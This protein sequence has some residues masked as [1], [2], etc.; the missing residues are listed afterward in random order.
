MQSN[1]ITGWA[2]SCNPCLVC[3]YP[4]P[5]TTRYIA[6]PSAT[7]VPSFVYLGAVHRKSS[8]DEYKCGD[9]D[10]QGNGYQAMLAFI[11]VTSL[12]VS[13]TTDT[14]NVGVAYIDTCGF[15]QR[16]YS[17]AY[18]LIS[19]T[20]SSINVS[21]VQVYSV[22]SADDAATLSSLLCPVGRP[23]IGGI[24]GSE[25]SNNGANCASDASCFT[26]TFP[27]YSTE[28]DVIVTVLLKMQWQSAGVIASDDSIGQK[29]L[30]AFI[31]SATNKSSSFSSAS[32]CIVNIVTI[33]NPYSSQQQVD[34]VWQRFQSYQDLRVIVVLVSNNIIMPVLNSYA[35][36]NLNSRYVLVGGRN[37]GTSTTF[38]NS[39]QLAIVG[40][41]VVTPASA[42]P[43]G[44]QSWLR[45]NMTMS[46]HAPIADDWFEEAWQALHKCKLANA[47]RVL[48]Q[49]DRIC[50]D[51][52]DPLD[53]LL[54]PYDYMIY[55]M[56]A[57]L[58]GV[59]SLQSV[60]NSVCGDS[61][62]SLSSAY[63]ACLKSLPLVKIQALLSSS[64]WKFPD[65]VLESGADITFSLNSSNA[66]FTVYN[67]QKIT[68]YQYKKVLKSFIWHYIVNT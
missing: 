27:D 50:S 53:K 62:T 12:L 33:S 52:E 64:S 58:A 13:T 36:Q 2:S 38:A 41:L 68:S 55:D 3:S 39:V 43:I 31:Q 34:S 18:N 5:V 59:K 51:N 49:F 56:A 20:T 67:F 28:T 40:S 6:S 7:H 47:T 24:F 4:L 46:S 44:F 45:S 17:D 15:T 35:S 66:Q 14:A 25:N 65:G 29:F 21:N 54:L 37:W 61:K 30:Q 32:I 16:T 22:N 60:I 8:S 10:V 23:L 63:N 11:Y 9:I 42:T 19:A 48:A 26:S 57:T 1:F